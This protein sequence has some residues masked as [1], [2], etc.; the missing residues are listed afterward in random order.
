MVKERF[1][2]TIPYKMT[3]GKETDVHIRDLNR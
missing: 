1:E 3:V 2:L